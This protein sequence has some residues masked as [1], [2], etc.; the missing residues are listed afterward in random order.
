S[1]DGPNA[2]RLQHPACQKEVLRRR[3][4]FFMPLPAFVPGTIGLLH[5]QAIGMHPAPHLILAARRALC[6]PQR[7]Q[8][9]HFLAF[10]G[11][12][13]LQ[14]GSR[15]VAQ[16]HTEGIEPYDERGPLLDRCMH[17]LALGIATVGHDDIAGRQG[18]MLERFARVDI[19][20]QHLEKLQGQQVHRDMQTMIGALRAWGLNTASTPTVCP[21]LA[22]RNL[23]LYQSL[24][25]TIP[26]RYALVMTRNDDP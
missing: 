19:A 16:R 5:V 20:D 15:R 23:L 21:F 6:H 8:R 18:E 26:Y 17:A 22:S 10:Q 3:R 4:A 9:F 12:A 11:G 7:A 14:R 13:Q 25:I 2:Y 1:K 24:P